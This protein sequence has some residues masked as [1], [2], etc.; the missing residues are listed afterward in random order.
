TGITQLR[1]ADLQ[2]D[3]DLLQQ[4]TKAAAMILKNYPDNARALVERWVK[5]GLS[6]GDVC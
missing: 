6:Y 3:G 1:I 2:R 4:V 5:E